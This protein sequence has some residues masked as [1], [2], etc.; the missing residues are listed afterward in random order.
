MAVLVPL[1]VPCPTMTRQQL[2]FVLRGQ[3]D[4]MLDL[5]FSP[6]IESVLSHVRPD[7]QKA[8]FSATWPDEVQKLSTQMMRE[9]SAVGGGNLQGVL[10]KIQVGCCVVVVVVLVVSALFALVCLPMFEVL[11]IRFPCAY[12]HGSFLPLATSLSTSIVF[13]CLNGVHVDWVCAAEQQPQRS[14]TV[15]LPG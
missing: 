9:H 14:A 12:I 4:R 2:S 13:V 1:R 7:C 11:C 10:Q 3:A 6:Y 5:G 8:L 15:L